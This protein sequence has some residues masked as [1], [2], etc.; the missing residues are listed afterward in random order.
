MERKEFLK[1]AFFSLTLVSANGCFT[2]MLY[3]PRSYD[4]TASAFLVTED[5][6]RVVV[7]GQRYHYIFDE[8]SPSL[9]QILLSPLELRTVVVAYLANFSVSSDNVVTG[10]YALYVWSRESDEQRKMAMDAGLVAPDVNLSGHLKG[11]RYSAEGFKFPSTAQ[12]QEFAHR[13]GA[14]IQEERSKA[15]KILLTPITVTADGALILGGL[16][17]LFL[18]LAGY[19]RALSDE[20]K[21]MPAPAR[22]SE[23]PPRPSARQTPQDRLSP[24]HADGSAE[25]RALARRPDDFLGGALS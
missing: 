25:G 23:A 11:V 12:P 22:A 18:L 15:A 8:I 5:G 1:G 17:L 9:K 24:D 3:K 16:L 21:P 6:S 20:G 14:S 2:P 4:E 19:G 7:L 13:Y 10:D